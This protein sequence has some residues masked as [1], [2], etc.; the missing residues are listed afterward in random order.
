[1]RW[2][3]SSCP[4]RDSF[5]LM[6]PPPLLSAERTVPLQAQRRENARL[7]PILNTL[8]HSD[9]VG[10]SGQSRAVVSH[11]IPQL[12]IGPAEEAA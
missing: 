7:L 11:E 5:H 1:V 2:R 12:H 4:C 9:Q 8:G 3:G 10:A 6:R